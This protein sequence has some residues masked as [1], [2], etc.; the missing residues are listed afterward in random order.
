VA[1]ERRR[2]EMREYQKTRCLY[3]HARGHVGTIVGRMIHHLPGA[4][5]S[6]FHYYFHKKEKKRDIVI[7]KDLL[8]IGNAAAVVVVIG[9]FVLV[10]ECGKAEEVVAICANSSKFA[11]FAP[12][13]FGPP[14]VVV[15]AVPVLLVLERA[16]ILLS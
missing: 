8:T 6:L 7:Q 2:L 14:P 11:I 5:R 13:P 9:V 1:E 12:L 10:F 16:F 4:G 15:V 3:A